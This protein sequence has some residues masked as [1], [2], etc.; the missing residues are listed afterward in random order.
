MINTHPRTLDRT[1]Q[2]FINHNSELLAL[3]RLD[4]ICMARHHI[5]IP[6]FRPSR[7]GML[8]SLTVSPGNAKIGNLHALRYIEQRIITIALKHDVG[9]IITGGADNLTGKIKSGI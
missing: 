3:R 9:I 7:I 5:Y 8:I 4:Q 6:S 2:K 1:L